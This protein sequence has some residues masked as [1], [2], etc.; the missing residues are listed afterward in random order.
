M[1]AP[2][3]LL[4]GALPF[5]LAACALLGRS[6]P[7]LRE[8]MDAHLARAEA[9]RSAVIQGDLEGARTAAE[10]LA[11][12]PQHPELPK[13]ERSPM[14]DLRAFSRCIVRTDQLEDAARA[15][16][17][18]AA[19]CGRC[20]VATEAGPRFGTAPMPQTGSSVPGHMRRH[21]WAAERM[22]EALVSSSDELWDQGATALTADPLVL[23]G[24]TDANPQANALARE[25][26]DLGTS[27]IGLEPD[28]RA[29][30][31]G[32]LLVTCVRCHELIDVPL[33][34]RRH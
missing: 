18:V 27:A 26:H 11:E 6:Q 12:H 33:R 7:T 9:A 16:A 23:G 2:K 30:V 25:V 13:G 4:V 24:S 20:H 10:W 15:T 32:R 14:E 28:H 1:P 5:A 29:A 31:Y 17:E 34:V 3:H 19:S 21:D 22:W 8:H